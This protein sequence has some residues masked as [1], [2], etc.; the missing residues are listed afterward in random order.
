[1]YYQNGED[2]RGTPGVSGSFG[3]GRAEEMEDAGEKPSQEEAGLWSPPP[4]QLADRQDRATAMAPRSPKV[5]QKSL[6]LESNSAT[7]YR[8]VQTRRVVNCSNKL[9]VFK[10]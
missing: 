2:S 4:K 10:F 5:V 7:A 6:N 3:T 9:I 8:S 1:M